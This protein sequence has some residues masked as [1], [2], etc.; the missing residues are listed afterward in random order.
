HYSMG[1]VITDVWGRTSVPG[2]YACGEVACTG[3]HGANR[4][5]SNSL[6]EGLVFGH[7]AGRAIREELPPRPS[8]RPKPLACGEPWPNANAA[9]ERLREVMWERVGISRTGEGLQAALAEIETLA[10]DAAGATCHPRTAEVRNMLTVSALIARAALI[11]EETRGGHYRADF[12]ERDDARWL[13]HIVFDRHGTRVRRN[14]VD[15]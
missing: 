3:I 2:L 11:R 1:G 5:A 15:W 6:L 8:L 9:A 14:L 10:S 13:C 12:P 4:L 7:R